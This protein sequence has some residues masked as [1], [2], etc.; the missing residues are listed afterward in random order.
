[1]TE[2]DRSRP[3][4]FAP[5]HGEIARRQGQPV[6]ADEPGQGHGHTGSR[7]DGEAG[8]DEGSLI[9]ARAGHCDRVGLGVTLP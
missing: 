2:H 1:M 5:S 4:N 6:I 7:N 8:F 9:T 3:L